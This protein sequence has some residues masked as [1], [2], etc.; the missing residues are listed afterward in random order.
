LGYLLVGAALQRNLGV[1]LD[2]LMARRLF[3]PL[4]LHVGSA[5]QWLSQGGFKARVAETEVV[6]WRGGQLSGVVHDENSWALSGHGSSGHAGLF[7][8]VVPMLRFGT[9]LV[10]ALNDAPGAL[11]ERASIAPLVQSRAGGT[12]RCG[13]DGKAREGSSAGAASGP[14]TFGHLGFTGT[15]MWCDPDAR[16]VT[17][18][19]TNRVN[20]TRENQRIRSARPRVHDRLFRLGRR[21]QSARFDRP[22]H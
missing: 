12:L 3:T 16:I 19:L 18:M 17:V 9:L 15:S 5:R 21:L 6:R 8:A 11:L 14:N 20:P 2:E 13:F 10:D 1:P 4:G 7:A 22:K